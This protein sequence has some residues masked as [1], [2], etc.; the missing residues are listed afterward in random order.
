M[1]DYISKS[2][3]LEQLLEARSDEIIKAVIGLVQTQPT[4][5]EKEII[6]KAFERVL[7]R[8]KC[9]E[10]TVCG[11]KDIEK[12]CGGCAGCSECKIEDAYRYAIEIFKEEGGIE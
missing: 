7:Q 12:N 3:L 10:G 2:A 8:L 6:R 4:I 9:A 5:S 1:R 11:H